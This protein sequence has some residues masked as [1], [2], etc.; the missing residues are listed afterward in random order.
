MEGLISACHMDSPLSISVPA[1]QLFEVGVFME[2]AAEGL[3]KHVF[4]ND[5]LIIYQQQ[6]SG[7]VR[8]GPLLSKM[9]PC[10]VCTIFTSKQF[11]P[12]IPPYL[13]GE[14]QHC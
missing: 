4:V 1:N 3:N 11:R 7:N 9:H 10:D 6:R 5:M 14:S 2:Y 8:I 12:T 13:C